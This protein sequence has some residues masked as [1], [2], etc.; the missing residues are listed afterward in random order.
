MLNL[1]TFAPLDVLSSTA[2]VVLSACEV[3]RKSAV[4]R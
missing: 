2:V 1:T 4:Y 3:S